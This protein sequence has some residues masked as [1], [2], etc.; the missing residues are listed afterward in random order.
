MKADI[1]GKNVLIVPRPDPDDPD[2]DAEEYDDEGNLIEVDKNVQL[3][4]EQFRNRMCCTVTKVTR[5]SYMNNNIAVPIN[6]GKSGYDLIRIEL[7]KIPLVLEAVELF[8][9]KT[10][11]RMDKDTKMVKFV[12][13]CDGDPKTRTPKKRDIVE[14]YQIPPEPMAGLIKRIDDSLQEYMD[15]LAWRLQ[16]VN[17]HLDNMHNNGTAKRVIED[18][19][20]P[21]EAEYTG[22]PDNP[23]DNVAVPN[24]IPPLDPP[25]DGDTPEQ[26]DADVDVVVDNNGYEPEVEGGTKTDDVDKGTGERIQNGEGGTIELQEV[27]GAML[28]EK[29]DENRDSQQ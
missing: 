15:L 8:E 2:P 7:E 14:Q 12:K 18:F 25:D 6:L 11:K 10:G 9:W 28:E 27:G 1:E 29:F 13:K 23:G 19:Q 24:I 21:K 5:M 3:K 20:L 26:K 4:V 22:N 17:A 16:C